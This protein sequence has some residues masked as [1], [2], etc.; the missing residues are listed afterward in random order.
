MAGPLI[1]KDTLNRK[2]TE[3][4][5]KFIS[6]II[7]NPNA[8]EIE[9]PGLNAATLKNDT[10]PTKYKV[11]VIKN[12]KIEF[13]DEMTS[14]ILPKISQQLPDLIQNTSVRNEN[15]NSKD[16]TSVLN[17]NSKEKTSVL[18]EDLKEETNVTDDG[19]NSKENVEPPP[20][21]DSPA[22]SKHSD[23]DIFAKLVDHYRQFNEKQL[24]L[25]S[26]TNLPTYTRT[27]NANID[28]RPPRN[29]DEP[30]VTSE[31]MIKE[32]V[33]RLN[34]KREEGEIMREPTITDNSYGTQPFGGGDY[35]MY[36]MIP[37]EPV[38]EPEIQMSTE[39]LT[40]LEMDMQLSNLMANK[41]NHIEKTLQ[42]RIDTKNDTCNQNRKW[43]TDDVIDLAHIIS[44]ERER[45]VCKD[46]HSLNGYP[47]NAQADGNKDD[48]V[49]M[50]NDEELS[51]SEL[52]L[53]DRLK[54]SPAKDDRRELQKFI[55]ENCDPN[56]TDKVI[57][58]KYNAYSGGEELNTVVNY[59]KGVFQ[60]NW[61][62]NA[63]E[64]IAEKLSRPEK[65]KETK[66]E[67]VEEP[68]KSIDETIVTMPIEI[69]N[70]NNNNWPKLRG[71]LEKIKQVSAWLSGGWLFSKTGKPIYKQLDYNGIDSGASWQQIY[72]RENEDNNVLKKRNVY[73]SDERVILSVANDNYCTIS[74]DNPAENVISSPL[75]GYRNT[76]KR[77][78]GKKETILDMYVDF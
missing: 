14:D 16:K 77:R 49:S 66:V 11:C 22:K 33:L 23:S 73:G 27:A 61:L 51:S 53:F 62:W 35:A 41:N 78:K 68:V 24:G 5:T 32:A 59:T 9:I 7:N 45:I 64:T 52:S 67:V 54:M 48:I 58:S 34:K 31:E 72:T 76:D 44:K 65:S 71:G 47:M 10:N 30:Q 46:S 75:L 2:S 60:I 18:I 57:H 38:C 42:N 29:D 6:N 43:K 70:R 26:H 50:I 1:L 40:T 8:S 56:K 12:G 19:T 39:N 25:K 37:K 69:E 3:D 74:D 15:R 63:Y 17:E 55:K 20:N 36:S 28:T 13:S 4:V 21:G